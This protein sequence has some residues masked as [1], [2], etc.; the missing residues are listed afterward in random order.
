MT[1]M[2]NPSKYLKK[3][4]VPQSTDHMKFKE[5]R[6]KKFTGLVQREVFTPAHVTDAKAHQI[7]KS[8]FVDHVKSEGTPAAYEK[9]RLVIMA[10]NDPSKTDILTQA[11]T[12]QRASQ[13]LQISLTA[14]DITVKMMFC[15]VI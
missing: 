15:D 1:K 13:L 5:S 14:S 6:N 4:G 10:F 8:R 12:V 11:P 9:S 3:R 2:L 7:F